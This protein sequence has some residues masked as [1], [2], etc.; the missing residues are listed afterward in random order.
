[1]TRSIASKIVKVDEQYVTIETVETR[2]GFEPF[3]STVSIKHNG[4][5]E[6]VHRGFHE[7]ISGAFQAGSEKV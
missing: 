2:P 3:R 7:L 1:M 4:S 6:E 5:P